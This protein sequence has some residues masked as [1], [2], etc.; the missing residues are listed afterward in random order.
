MAEQAD[1]QQRLDTVEANL[2]EVKTTLQALLH[3]Q[4]RQQ[5]AAGKAEG[6]DAAG[7]WIAGEL[8]DMAAQGNAEQDV[9]GYAMASD[10]HDSVTWCYSRYVCATMQCGGSSWC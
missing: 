7:A 4:L 3:A 8:R 5:D 9:A 6:Q 1:L 10:P 2:K